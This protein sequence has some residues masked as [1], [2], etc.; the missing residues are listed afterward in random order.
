MMLIWRG[1]GILVPILLFVSAWITSYWFPDTRLA[2][3]TFMGWSLLWSGIV[4]LLLGLA[5]LGMNLPDPET[6]KKPEKSYH[7]FFWIPIWIWGVV[8]IGLSIWLINKTEVSENTSNTPYEV[9]DEEKDV[10]ANEEEVGGER[11]FHF[12]NN[13]NDSVHIQLRD[14]DDGLEYFDFYVGANSN[15]F[16]NVDVLKYLLLMNDSPIEMVIGAYKTKSFQDYNDAWLVLGANVDLLLVDVTSVCN[17]TIIVSEIKEVNWLDNVQERYEGEWLIEP[18]ISSSN[19]EF[20]ISVS[21][22]GATLPY[23]HKENQ[24]IYALI[25]IPKETQTSEEFLD[26]AVVMLCFD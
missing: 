6:N 1:A 21:K 16:A 4:I 20:I 11:T 14:F 26:E 17:D 10:S 15:T 8:F 19:D 18:Y 23:S 3:A 5:T 2:N 7:D 22:P 12:Y 25:P 9:V 24:I 13:T